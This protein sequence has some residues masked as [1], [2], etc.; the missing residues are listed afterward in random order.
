MRLCTNSYG[1][2]DGEDREV[3]DSAGLI[4][5]LAH[6]GC[7]RESGDAVTWSHL[8]GSG[9]LGESAQGSTFVLS[10]R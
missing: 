6:I 9:A 3:T 1:Q 10:A 4:D 8:F 5:H 2:R 7:D